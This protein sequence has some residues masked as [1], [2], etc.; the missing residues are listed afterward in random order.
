MP[1]PADPLEKSL[2]IQCG[3]AGRGRVGA[4]LFKIGGLWKINVMMTP[5]AEGNE[6]KSHSSGH[7]SKKGFPGSQ[8]VAKKEGDNS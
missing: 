2:H 7:S 1:S 4:I 5:C 8:E 3:H 6:G